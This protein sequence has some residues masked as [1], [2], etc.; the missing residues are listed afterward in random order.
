M[1]YDYS[2]QAVFSLVGSSHFPVEISGPGPQ[3]PNPQ[4]L[5]LLCAKCYN[6]WPCPTVLDYRAYAQAHSIPV[7]ANQSPLQVGL[8][9]GGK[10]VPPRLT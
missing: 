1:P 2:D 6:P 4:N 8:Q 7:V 10:L 5:S 9:Q 3:P